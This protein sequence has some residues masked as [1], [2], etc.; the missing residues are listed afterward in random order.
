[1]SQEKDLFPMELEKFQSSPAVSP[2]KTSAYAGIKKASKL[3]GQAYGQKSPV[4][5][6]SLCPNTLLWR[7]SQTCLVAQASQEGNGTQRLGRDRV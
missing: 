4:F 2:V 6:A 5:V 1:M 7:P 3:K